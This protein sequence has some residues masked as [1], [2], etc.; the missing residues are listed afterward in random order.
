MH[1]HARPPNFAIRT[2]WLPSL[3]DKKFFEV[4]KK[5]A[6]MGLARRYFSAFGIHITSLGSLLIFIAIL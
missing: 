2:H 3:T 5:V 1:S 6:A 4:D